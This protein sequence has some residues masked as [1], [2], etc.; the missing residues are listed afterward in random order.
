MCSCQSFFSLINRMW[1]GLENTQTHFYIF[2]HIIINSSEWIEFS[3]TRF[4]SQRHVHII[5]L[6]K[7]LKRVLFPES[8]HCTINA[9]IITIMA[10]ASMSWG[11]QT[12]NCICN[13]KNIGCI[14]W[15]LTM[16]N[17]LNLGNLTRVTRNTKLRL[18]IAVNRPDTGW[19]WRHSTKPSFLMHLNAF[20]NFQYIKYHRFFFSYIDLNCMRRSN[21]HERWWWGNAFAIAIIAKRIAFCGGF[22]SG[23]GMETVS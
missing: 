2:A 13:T 21:M 8:R 20:S 19:R 7:V 16:H 11:S 12:L 5:F 9:I 14:S 10:L 18:N 17:V 4:F 1:S 23:L 6:M 3:S 15:K 22:G